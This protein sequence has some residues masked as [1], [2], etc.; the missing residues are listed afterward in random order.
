MTTYI[1]TSDR[2]A[3]EIELRY[4]LRNRLVH[5]DIRADL[6]PGHYGFFTRLLPLAEDKVMTYK[7]DTSRVRKV[8]L[9]LTFER[10]WQ[11]Y[12]LRKSRLRAE[13]LW[14]RLSTA[15]RIGALAYI[16]IY[17][18]ELATTGYAQKYPDTYLRDKP[19]NDKK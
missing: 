14:D 16:P 4:D 3:G 15:D 5:F 7:T 9:D 12:G 6:E 10:F 11:L 18:G 2:F 13:R 19:W 17:L 8:P 1:I